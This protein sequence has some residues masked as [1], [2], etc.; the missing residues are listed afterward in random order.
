MA[1][2]PRRMAGKHQRARTVL[3]LA[4]LIVAAKGAP[5]TAELTEFRRRCTLL[6]VRPEQVWEE[7]GG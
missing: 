4:D 2:K 5:S 3:R 6:D 7:L 1:G